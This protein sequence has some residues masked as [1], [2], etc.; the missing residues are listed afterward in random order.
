ML[1]DDQESQLV[2]VDYQARLMPAIFEGP[3]V[4]A[5]AVRLAFHEVQASVYVM[6]D[7]D[8]TYHPEDLPAMLAPVLEKRADLVIGDR[9]IVVWNWQVISVLIAVT[10]TT[11]C[12]YPII[13]GLHRKVMRRTRAA[14]GPD[15]VLIFRISAMDML[16]GQQTSGACSVAQW[17][18]VEA[19][20]GP[21]GFIDDNNKVFKERRD[22]VVSML[23]QANGLHCPTP[24]GAFYV[25]PS[26]AG[27]IGKTAPT[28]EGVA[29]F[30]GRYLTEPKANVFFDPPD[31]PLT[32]AAFARAVVRALQAGSAAL[33]DGS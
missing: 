22:L 9:A 25:Y 29:G 20:N 3:Q 12:F 27:L 7:A 8:L 21:Q 2:L 23:N 33:L 18:S 6:I 24:E 28:R 5:N 31:E 30:L 10:L 13:L 26:C 16:Q 14:V 32:D 4:L 19:L 17:A 15:F 11:A 1:L